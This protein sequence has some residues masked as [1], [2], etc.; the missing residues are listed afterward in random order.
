MCNCWILSC[1]CRNASAEFTA[2]LDKASSDLDEFPHGFTTA[3]NPVGCAIG[4][5]VVDKIVNG[6]VFSNLVEVVPHFQKRLNEFNDHPHVG[7]VRGVGLM[8]AIEV[9]KDRDKKLPFDPSYDV[10]E[11]LAQAGYREGIIIRP[12]GNAV[13]FAPPFIINESQ[14]DELFDAFS[15]A[16]KSTL[17]Q[18]G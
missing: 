16:L 9:V 12:I 17:D 2:E 14:I 8:G 6:G 4:L 3:G 18:I 1:R 7:E 15:R 5:A 13:L 10:S 11:S